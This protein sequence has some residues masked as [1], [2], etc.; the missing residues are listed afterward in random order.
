MF[1]KK[2]GMQIRHFNG[3]A[4]GFNLFTE[5]TNIFV[6]NIGDF[7]EYEFFNFSASDFLHR[8]PIAHIAQQSVPRTKFRFNEGLSEFDYPLFVRV[9]DN[10]CSIP[11]DTFLENNNFTGFVVLPNADNVH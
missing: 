1:E 9:S 7:F 3:V 11:V 10:K 6:A 2:L 5:P 4:D 8:N